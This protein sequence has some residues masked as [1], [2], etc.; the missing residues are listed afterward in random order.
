MNINLSCPINNTGYGIASLNILKQ[1]YLLNKNISY[2]PIGQPRLETESDHDLVLSLYQNSTS[3]DPRAPF[4]KIWHQFDLAS[5]IGKGK[6]YAMSFFELDTFNPTEL[7]HL[8]V[9]DTI[10]VTCNWAKSIIEKNNI[11]TPVQVI[12]LGVDTTIFDSNKYK[13]VPKDK[14]VFMNIGKWEVRKGHDILLELFQKAFPKEKDV[15]LCLLASE[16]TNNYSSAQDL[17]RWKNMYNTDS[18]VRLISGVAT[19]KEIAEV[20]NYADCGV[21]PSRAEGWNLE[22]LEMMSMNKPVIATNYSAHTEYCNKDNAYLVDIDQTEKAQDGKAFIGQGNWAKIEKNQKDQIIEYMRYCY[23]NRVTSN[24][25]GV[26]TA[27]KYS[28]TNS[29]KI[30][31]G[32]ISNG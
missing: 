23:N 32:C 5:H 13:S 25:A 26:E 14:Y 7:S 12:P 21:F 30:L 27:R 22:L 2:F 16:V 31:L 11:D 19:H 9:P 18:R 15:E 3:F 4:I 6:Y 29:A 1:L 20:I 8:S 28:W 17:E 10:W 24:Q